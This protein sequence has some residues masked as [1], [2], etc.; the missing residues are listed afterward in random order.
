[1][2]WKRWGG[3]GRGGALALPQL[4]A[5]GRGLQAA[6]GSESALAVEITEALLLSEPEAA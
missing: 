3:L 5:L 6:S 1:M 2:H 4:Y